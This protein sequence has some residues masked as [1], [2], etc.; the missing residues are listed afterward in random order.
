[1]FV[2]GYTDVKVVLRFL[3]LISP[4]DGEINNLDI[5]KYNYPDFNDLTGAM[6]LIY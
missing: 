1:M 2:I 4:R 6:H 3:F 5:F